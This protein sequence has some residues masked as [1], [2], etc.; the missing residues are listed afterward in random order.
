MYDVFHFVRAYDLDQCAIKDPNIPWQL[1]Q[2]CR[3]GN[4]L[5]ICGPLDLIHKCMVDAW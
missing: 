2:M 5:L 3:Q 1:P 4:L